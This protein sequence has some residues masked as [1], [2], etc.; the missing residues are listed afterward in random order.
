MTKEPN[1]LFLTNKSRSNLEVEPPLRDTLRRLS[2]GELPWPLLL[3]GLPG[4]GK[5]CAAMSFLD[6]VKS[7]QPK[8]RGRYIHG[9]YFWT[10]AEYYQLVLDVKFGRKTDVGI[11]D[12]RRGVVDE[13]ALVVLDEVDR[14]EE[15]KDGRVEETLDVLDRREGM[16]LI[17]LSNSSPD[18]LGQIYGERLPSRL[19]NGVIYEMKGVDRRKHK[20]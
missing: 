18:V 20:A 13:A 5:T 11:D 19:A 16:P 9:R 7:I 17:L 14:A 12:F 3:W 6:H 4:R 10:V 15:I 8:W 2:K 1:A